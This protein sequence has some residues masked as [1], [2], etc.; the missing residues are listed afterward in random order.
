MNVSH[1]LVAT[2]H[3]QV[4]VPNDSGPP[5]AKER[6]R[7]GSAA[8]DRTVKSRPVTVGPGTPETVSITQGLAAG[9]S[10]ITDGGDRLRDGAPVVLPGQRP[11]TGGHSRGGHHRRWSGGGAPDGQ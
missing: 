7:L 2:L 6:L 5:W 10:V 11:G 4:I 9:E 3:D 1:L 8:R